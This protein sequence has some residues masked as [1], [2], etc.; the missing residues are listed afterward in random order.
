[1][2]DKVEE[3]D[4]L[5]DVESAEMTEK[6]LG[7]RLSDTTVTCIEDKIDEIEREMAKAKRKAADGTYYKIVSHN[8]KNLKAGLMKEWFNR[9]RVESRHCN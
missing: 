3:E 4:T 6:V 5:D 1:M 8:V 2:Y 7:C 9:V